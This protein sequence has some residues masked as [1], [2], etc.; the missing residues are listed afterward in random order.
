MPRVLKAISILAYVAAFALIGGTILFAL[1][2]AHFSRDL[3]RLDPL[4]NYQPWNQSTQV[5][6][7]DGTL[8]GEFYEEDRIVIDIH[9][10]PDVMKKAIIAV[11]DE[12][13]DTTHP[14]AWIRGLGI[15]PIGITR[16]AVANIIPGGGIQGGS[17]LTQ[18]LAKMMFLTSERTFSRKFQE[19]I[20]AYRIEKEFSRDEIMERYMNKVFFGNRA[21]G[22]HS[23]ASRYFGV[24]LGKPDAKLTLG[25]AA[26]L[27]GLVKAPSYYA[28]HKHPR[29]AKDRQRITL[30]RMVDRGY[31]PR[32]AVEPAIKAFWESFDTAKVSV[33]DED[34]DLTHIKVT[35]AGFFVEY[36]RQELLKVLSMDQILRGGYKIQTTL[37][38]KMQSA[39]EAA[40]RTGLARLTKD[41]AARKINLAKGPLEGA[42]IAIDHTNGRILAMVGGSSWSTTNQYNRAV[43]AKR[44]AGSS[45]KPIVYFTALEQGSATL[46]TVL[47]DEPFTVPGTDWSPQNYDGSY[48]GPVLP[49]P[50]LTHSYN[51]AAVQMLLLA[52]GE[53]I[54]E[55]ASALG[56]DVSRMRPYPSMALGAFE[57]SLLEL[58]SAYSAFAN[59]GARSEPYPLVSISDREGRIVKNY[60][61]YAT[62]QVFAAEY[63]FL[64]TSLMQ[65]VVRNGTAASAVGA[66]IGKI[67]AAGKTGTT[68]DYAD[69]WFVGYTPTV[70][71]GVWIG[72][73]ERRTMGR[74]MTGGKAAGTIWADFIR[75]ALVKRPVGKFPEPTGT[76]IRVPICNLTGLRP[77]DECPNPVEEYFINHT[78][79]TEICAVHS[80]I[81]TLQQFLFADYG[82]DTAMTAWPEPGAFAWPA[83]QE[84]APSR[85]ALR[86]IIDAEAP[87]PEGQRANPFPTAPYSPEAPVYKAPPITE[88]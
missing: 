33:P 59:S 76:L 31:I 43:Q 14:Q 11:E 63:S 22:L 37:D 66:R 73:D 68:D 88:E 86:A 20:L 69:A 17:T 44:Q 19:M 79:P 70:T 32:D 83:A 35:Q 25:Q 6:A 5:F 81:T 64:M 8:I 16:A 84:T 82:G 2:V 40:M 71:A 52:T 57:V 38:P 46:G 65:S 42:L 36:V 23:A 13:F 21:H 56:I 80:D 77:S 12:R 48:H 78:A 61:P 30:L 55:R 41:V 34:T 18:Q 85:E 75:A 50:A 47:R 53:R 49:R 10:I 67:P 62:H 4:R 7:S 29:R 1:L 60:E 15:D 27:A 39:A 72:F 51:V 3:P 24:D 28:P 54:I 26:L 45:F 9:S 58:T 87:P 74:G